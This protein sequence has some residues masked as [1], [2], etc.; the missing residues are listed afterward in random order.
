MTSA[1]KTSRDIICSRGK[2]VLTNAGNIFYANLISEHKPIYQ[3]LP[4]IKAKRALVLDLLSI[5][6]SGDTPRRFL[7]PSED[8][9]DDGEEIYEELSRADSVKKIAQALREKPKA[10][11]KN[12]D[13]PPNTKEAAAIPPDELTESRKG[14]DCDHGDHLTDLPL[15]LPT[16][17]HQRKRNPSD[18][19]SK[20][21]GIRRRRKNERNEEKMTSFEGS[22]DEHGSEHGGPAVVS[23]DG[24]DHEKKSQSNE[25]EDMPVP[26]V[27]VE[28]FISI[29]P[30]PLDQI[31]NL[32]TIDPESSL[33]AINN[34]DFHFSEAEGN[35]WLDALFSNDYFPPLLDKNSGEAIDQD[36]KETET[37][38]LFSAI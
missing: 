16:P 35:N 4:N 17:R 11:G 30:I 26:G 25:E 10:K 27:A 22:F 20:S 33:N 21:L 18:H 7:K 29:S 28:P 3:S 34:G 14:C 1:L 31:Q 36:G 2:G 37:R 5:I 9:G 12:T 6:E 32:E 24:E 8:D 19:Y 38:I 15:P 13:T 23:N